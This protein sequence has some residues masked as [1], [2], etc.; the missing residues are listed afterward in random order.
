V[1][2]GTIKEMQ[3]TSEMKKKNSYYIRN[4]PEPM[5][6]HQISVNYQATKKKAIANAIEL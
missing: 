3:Y 5:F 4:T 2:F 1:Q 6:K